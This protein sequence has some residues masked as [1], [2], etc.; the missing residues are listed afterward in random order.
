M[1]CSCGHDFEPVRQHRHYLVCADATT[2]EAF[3]AIPG[4]PLVHLT[5]TSP[6]YGNQRDYKVGTGFDWNAVVPA[7]IAN[8]H[9][10]GVP[11]H[12]ALIN[13]GLVHRERRVVM[14]WTSLL[15]RMEAEGAPLFGW[16]VWDQGCALPGD[17]NGR[18]GPSHEFVFHFAAAA[19]QANKIVECK[20]AG[21][22]HRLSSTGDTSGLR[23]AA[24]G[25][26]GWNGLDKKVQSHKIPDSVIR[27]PRQYGGVPGHPAPFSVAFAKLVIDA[28]SA[29]GDF[30]CDPFVGSG[31]TV[32]AAEQA[33]RRCIGIDIAPE[34]IA[35]ALERM[36]TLGVA[37]EKL[38]EV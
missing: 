28:Y 9:S 37:V 16:Y 29:P 17:W 4:K 36:A 8:C 38:N 31:T 27:E 7:V 30:V 32:I 18:L 20:C 26:S 35:V 24:G 6:P 10:H 2:K 21:E 13:L 19:R 11:D 15:E 25:R 14:Y 23:N 22:F 12:Q 1:R 34:Y 3:E 33:G 5:F